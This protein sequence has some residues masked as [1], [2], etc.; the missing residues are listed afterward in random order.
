MTGIDAKATKKAYKDAAKEEKGKMKDKEKDKQLEE[1]QDSFE[2]FWNEWRSLAKEG[3][4]DDQGNVI[5]EGKFF[6][7][8]TSQG[9]AHF[10][11]EAGHHGIDEDKAYS[12]LLKKLNEKEGN[13]FVGGNKETTLVDLRRNMAAYKKQQEEE[14]MQ[15]QAAYNARGSEFEGSLTRHVEAIHAT[16]A[17]IAEANTTI[18]ESALGQ[19]MRRVEGSGLPKE[20]R[21]KLLSEMRTQLDNPTKNADGK[22]TGID[23]AGRTSKKQLQFI[24]EFNKA[25]RAAGEE[26]GKVSSAMSKLETAEKEQAANQQA[27]SATLKNINSEFASVGNKI[28]DFGEASKKT[29]EELDKMIKT[30]R[31]EMR[32]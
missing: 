8:A 20:S 30:V 5:K 26:L 7:L 14:A 22:I 28:G 10:L 19:I 17:S 29:G 25:L 15:R 3:Q 2:A 21:D 16:E 27:L 9:Q 11:R 32:K 18:N 6:N 1:F 31:Q 13:G 12:M 24:D 23:T 4:K